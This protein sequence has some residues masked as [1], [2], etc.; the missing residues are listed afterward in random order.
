[1][2][3]VGL[4]NQGTSQVTLETL[5]IPAYFDAQGGNA[6]SIIITGTAL[7][8]YTT[9]HLHNQRSLTDEEE[10]A[11]DLKVPYV[12]S[13]EIPE[14]AQVN[15]NEENGGAMVSVKATMVAN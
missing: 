3:W 13:A 5:M 4:Q 15:A 6:G 10:A 14:V 12:S 7:I 1:M 9:C 2:E 8:S 11:F